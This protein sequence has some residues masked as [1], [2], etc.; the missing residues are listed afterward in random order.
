MIHDN[1]DGAQGEG[2]GRVAAQGFLSVYI[3][4]THGYMWPLLM[5]F[6]V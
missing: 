1:V 2:K 5:C 3:S 4:F 6:K